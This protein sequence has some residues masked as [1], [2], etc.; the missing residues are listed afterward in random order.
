M[1][2]DEDIHSK[3][4]SAIETLVH[5]DAILLQNDV[6]ERMITAKLVCY[7]Q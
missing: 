3:I 2:D 5:N 1:F 6:A 7:I 4:Q